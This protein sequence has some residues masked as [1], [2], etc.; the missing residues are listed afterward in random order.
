MIKI[1]TAFVIGFLSYLF[2][3]SIFQSI[4]NIIIIYYLIDK[5]NLDNMLQRIAGVPRIVPPKEETQ[6]GVPGIIPPKE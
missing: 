5:N 2:G 6:S 4:L 1:G 3:S